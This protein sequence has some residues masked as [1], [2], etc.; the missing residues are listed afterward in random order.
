MKI[1]VVSEEFFG[2]LAHGLIRFDRVDDVAALEER[3]CGDPGARADVGDG[4]GRAKVE[5]VFEKVVEGG[6]VVGARADVV[7]DTVGEAG[8]GAHA[9]GMM[10]QLPWMY[11]DLG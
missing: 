3:V 8:G 6:G 1:R 4:H 10:A 9:T 7:F 2:G 5:V 11:S